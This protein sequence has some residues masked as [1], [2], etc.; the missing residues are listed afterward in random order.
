MAKKEVYPPE[1]Y[2]MAPP[3]LVRY[4]PSYTM[5]GTG[6]MPPQ[7]MMPIPGLLYHPSMSP[8]LPP[9]RTTQA[10]PPIQT[11]V[12]PLEQR[13]LDLLYPDRD[14]C[15][16]AEAGGC[17]DDERKVL[18]LCDNIAFFIRHTQSSFGKI[19]VANDVSMASR[20]WRAFKA[21]SGPTGRGIFVNR[22]GATHNIL[23]VKVEPGE[24][25]IDSLTTQI[26]GMVKGFFPELWGSQDL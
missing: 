12:D 6:D 13:I 18:I 25:I 9:S 11:P 3:Q 8:A 23:R 21:S 14:E 24:K 17:I 16:I 7:A 15:F 2:T 19:S 26:D 20:N 10:I 1:A 5:S 4:T 22:S